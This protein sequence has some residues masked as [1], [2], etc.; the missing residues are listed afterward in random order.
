MLIT[1]KE[2]PLLKPIYN[3]SYKL[4]EDMRVILWNLLNNNKDNIDENDMKIL[5]KKLLTVYYE[6]LY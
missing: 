3:E 4:I 5:T 1:N 6:K 2:E